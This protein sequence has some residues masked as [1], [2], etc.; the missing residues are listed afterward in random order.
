MSVRTMADDELERV[1]A[2]PIAGTGLRD[3]WLHRDIERDTYE[4]AHGEDIET[5]EVWVADEVHLVTNLTD[6]EIDERFDE[7]WDQAELD[8]TGTRDIALGARAANDDTDLAVADLSE[9]VS[10][11]AISLTDLADAVA[12]LSQMVS[13]LKS[14]E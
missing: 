4:D 6:D 10:D 7:L 13:D 12:E 8:G 3:V 11:N 9:T 2:E 5:R 14:K 1:H